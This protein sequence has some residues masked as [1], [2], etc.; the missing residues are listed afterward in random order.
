MNFWR[1]GSML[2]DMWGRNFIASQIGRNVIAKRRRSVYQGRW[3]RNVIAR[4]RILECP[5]F[6]SPSNIWYG[7][8]ISNYECSTDGR[9]YSSELPIGRPY[10]TCGTGFLGGVCFIG[11]ISLLRMSRW[12]IGITEPHRCDL[13][14]VG[15]IYRYH[16]ATPL[17]QESRRD[18]LLVPQ[19]HIYATQVP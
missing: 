10:G 1:W 14:H 12:D 8:S 18:D 19:S 9:G 16:Q 13:I 5:F 2:K 3:G 4:R 7:R 15:T 17:R 11:F 6:N